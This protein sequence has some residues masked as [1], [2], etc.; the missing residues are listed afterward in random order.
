[1]LVSVE[2]MLVLIIVEKY[3][4]LLVVCDFVKICWFIGC[5]D[6][7]LKVVYLLIISLNFWLG[8]DFVQV[9][10]C[11]IM[12]DVIVKKL[13]GKWIVYINLDVYFCLCINWLYVE[14]FVR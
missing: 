6:E 1:M 7:V 9:E 14:I 2:C 11:Y 13:K 12:L 4:E 5:D 3:F 8:V 10:V